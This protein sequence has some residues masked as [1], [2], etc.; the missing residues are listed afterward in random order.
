MLRRA[1]LLPLLLLPAFA[2]SPAPHLDR[3]RADLSALTAPEM[4]GR[5]SLDPGA[6]KAARYLADQFSKAGLTPVTQEFRLTAYDADP[7]RRR[8]ILTTAKATRILGA[9]GELAGGFRRDLTVS[10]P[11][12]FAGYGITAPEYGYDDYRRVDAAGKIVLL[13]DHE[14]QENDPASVFNGTG[15]TI[16]GARWMKVRNAERHGARAVLIASEP[17]RTHRGLFDSTL[18]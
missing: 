4:A 13:F 3:M 17:L 6:E 15:H 7:T 11:I 14:P 16:H 1:S 9:A 18:R 10:A 12:V 5:L 8:L 2:Q